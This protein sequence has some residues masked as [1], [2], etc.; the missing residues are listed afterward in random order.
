MIAISI[1]FLAGRFH[2]T[3]WGHQVNEGEVEW[4]PSPWRILRALCAAW[5]RHEREA[6]SDEAFLSLLARLAE[7]PLYALPEARPAHTRHYMPWR[8]QGEMQ[9]TLVLDTFVAPGRE[10]ELYAIWPGAE[11][12]VEERK[13]LAR[14]LRHVGYFGRAESWAELRLVEDPPVCNARPLSELDSAGPDESEARLLAADGP[15]DLVAL[16]LETLDMR[17]AGRSIPPRTRWV[18]YARPAEILHPQSRRKAR[19]SAGIP[20][21]ALARYALH[22]AART[23]VRFTLFFAED[24]RRALLSRAEGRSAVFSGREAGAPRQDGHRH[25]FYLP[26]DVDGDG[27][28]DHLTV[29]SPEGFGLAERRA[30]ESFRV[31]LRHGK[32]CDQ[33]LLLETL[34][35][36]DSCDPRSSLCAG[37][38]TEWVSAT[39]F[40]L[41][42]HPKRNGK[43][44]PVAQLRLELARRGLPEPLEMDMLPRPPRGP[45]SLEWRHFRRRRETQPPA[46]DARSLQT[47]FGFRLRFDRPVRGPIALG[48]ACHFGLGLFVP[49]ERA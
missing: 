24:A 45:Q 21:P 44:G 36:L 30:L 46:V 49:V 23:P 42:R 27:R 14:L 31:L 20:G 29:Y 37:L 12:S 10:A 48:Y 18:R 39:P 3:P 26:E 19:V 32:G 7:P 35:P 41:L 40:C 11:L 1:R 22:A 47:A 4:P 15:P 33:H 25:A 13:L 43:D 6:V 28:L 8:K 16:L 5:I 2:A 9:T 34:A 17:R 38:S